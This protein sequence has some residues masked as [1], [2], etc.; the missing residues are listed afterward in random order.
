M[1]SSLFDSFAKE[2]FWLLPSIYAV[3]AA[4]VALFLANVLKSS[5]SGLARRSPSHLTEVIARS[6]PRPLA[7]AIFLAEISGGLRWL[8][9]P[10][11][12]E[13]LTRHLLPF[14]LGILAVLLLMR[15]AQR[16]IEAFGR[17]NPALRSTAG[18][19]RAVTWVVGLVLVALLTSDA[20]GIS[21]APVLTA[22]G[23]GSLAVALALQD[24]LSNFFAGISLVADKPVRPG[25]FVR[26]DS[27]AEG[28]VEAIGWRSTHLR[29][30]GG[31]IVVVPNGTLAK[32]VLTN[33]GTAN[34]RLELRVRIDV[35]FEADVNQVETTFASEGPTLTSIEGV[36]H[37]PAPCV[38]FLPGPVPYGLGFTIVLEV[39]PSVDVDRVEHEVRKRLFLAMKAAKIDVARGLPPGAPLA[40]P[41]KS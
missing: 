37:E 31:G 7:F 23:I 2:P 28:Y 27:G 33:F 26:L 22:L 9:M 11:H 36:K 25:D 10:R 34:P 17:S 29:R 24:T 35:A 18:L 13:A 15:V 20:L 32:G 30:Q 40:P 3:L 38:L 8:P 16:A 4:V 1:E 5:M 19:G 39:E 12:L 21:L 6:A 14:A 41:P